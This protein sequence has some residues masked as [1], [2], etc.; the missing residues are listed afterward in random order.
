MDKLKTRKPNYNYVGMGIAVGVAV[1]A[2]M[3]NIAVGIALGIVFGV[4]LSVSKYNKQKK[5][6]SENGK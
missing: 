4:I 3:N 1:G 5:D 6:Q 2:A